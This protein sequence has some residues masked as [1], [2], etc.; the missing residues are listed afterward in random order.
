M[1]Q[2]GVPRWTEREISE[3]VEDNEVEAQQAFDQL[4]CLVQGFFLLECVDEVDPG[5]DA[6]F[7]VVMFSGRTSIG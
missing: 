4:A 5:E 2:E 7:F 1:E 6:D 3:L